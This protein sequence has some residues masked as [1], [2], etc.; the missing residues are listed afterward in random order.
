MTDNTTQIL[1]GQDVTITTQ[2]D[3]EAIGTEISKMDSLTDQQVTNILKVTVK[4][5]PTILMFFAIQFIS[6]ANFR[7]LVANNNLF[8]PWTQQL[9]KV[10][11]Y[12]PQDET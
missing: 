12:K 7:Q 3:A 10:K 9:N 11:D 8:I 4:W 6:N 1:N 2:A 5:D